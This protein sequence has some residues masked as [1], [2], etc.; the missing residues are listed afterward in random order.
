MDDKLS[1]FSR[2][3]RTKA[4]QISVETM[5]LQPSLKMKIFKIY[6]MDSN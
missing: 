5:E 6:W 3:E 4:L 1:D 2:I